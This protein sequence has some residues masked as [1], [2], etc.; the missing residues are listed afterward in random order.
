MKRATAALLVAVLLAAFPAAARSSTQPATHWK[1]LNEALTP[2]NVALRTEV[3]ALGKNFD[4]IATQSFAI[5]M[6]APL[7]LPDVRKETDKLSR[8]IDEAQGHLKAVR[9]HAEKGMIVLDGF[10][11]ESCFAHFWAYEFTMFSTWHESAVQLLAQESPGAI[12]A[13]LYLGGYATSG[14]RIVAAERGPIDDFWDDVDC[15]PT[16]PSAQPNGA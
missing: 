5:L 16:A 9:D 10:A 13:A 1:D 12:G 11:V 7:N 2:V 14:Y 8:L 15:L 4:D 6:A 3:T